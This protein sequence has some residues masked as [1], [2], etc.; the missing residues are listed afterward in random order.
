MSS[1]VNKLIVSQSLKTLIVHVS[2]RVVNAFNGVGAIFFEALKNKNKM[3][4]SKVS[5]AMQAL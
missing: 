3:L 1:L 5:Y 4:I 2:F